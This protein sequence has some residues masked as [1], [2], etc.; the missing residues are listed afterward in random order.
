MTDICQA[1]SDL[2]LIGFIYDDHYR[3]V[4]P[5]TYGV[6]KYDHAALRCYQIRGGSA[7][8]QTQGWKIF[9]RDDMHGVTV[10]EETFSGP[11][12]GYSKDDKIFDTIQCQL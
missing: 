4:E 10:L 9:R 12:R 1:I 7:S 11:R 2:Q 5:H 6:D 3:V 8:G